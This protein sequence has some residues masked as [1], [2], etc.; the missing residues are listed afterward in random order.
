MTTTDVT[1]DDR[2][3]AIR[4]VRRKR[5]FRAELT[6]YLLVN[7]I[8]WGV[9]FATGGAE[10]QGYWPAWVSAA[11]GIGLAISAWHTFGQK[12]ISEAA[13]DAELQKMH[14]P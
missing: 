8:L 2:D 6:S 10:E 12:P 7:A 1:T 4:A 5:G 3:L 11:W 14:R 9:W 13:I